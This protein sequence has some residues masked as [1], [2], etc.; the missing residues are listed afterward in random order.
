M[1][2]LILRG[3]GTNC[4]W[5]TAHAFEMAGSQTQR[6]HINALLETPA[7]LAD[8]QVV[9]V[10]GGFSYGD[11]LGAGRVLGF[12]MRQKLGDH[13]Q[14][15]RDDGKLILGICNGFQV[16]LSCGL[17][18]TPE[19]ESDPAGQVATDDPR[20][21]GRRRATLALNDGGRFLN[22]WVYLKTT[23]SNCVFLRDIQRMALPM[24]HAEGKFVTDNPQTLEQLDQNQQ[25]TLR[26]DAPSGRE[27]SLGDL[28]ANPNGSTWDV[29]GVC[30]PSGR[31]L[32]LMPHPE[33]HVTRTHHFQWTRL[34]GDYPTADGL[35]MFQ[36]AVRYFQQ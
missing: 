29:A 33:R 32:G 12:Q 9:C 23:G 34:P 8:F 22:R 26:Y 13:L 11:D 19:I 2:T 27:V 6:V 36:N 3:P 4:D 20:A 7:M 25:L 35:A 14:R 5:E 15:F 21:F 17:L 10:P 1:K 28:P 18:V 24:A 30:D 31:V 16:L